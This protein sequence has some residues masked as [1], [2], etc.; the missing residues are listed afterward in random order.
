[1]D[2]TITVNNLDTQFLSETLLFKIRRK[3]ILTLEIINPLQRLVN[4]IG[5]KYESDEEKKKKTEKGNRITK[6]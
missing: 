6:V 5:S 1:M 4:Q 2:F 3:V